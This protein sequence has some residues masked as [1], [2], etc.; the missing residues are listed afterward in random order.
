M[1]SGK[2]LRALA[3]KRL[4]GEVSEEQFRLELSAEKDIKLLRHIA[5]ELT[6]HSEV[7]IPAYQ[8]A[9]ELDPGDPETVVDLGFVHWLCGE[10]DQARNCLS[11]AYRLAP[12]HVKALLL[13][14]AL[15]SDPLKKRE[16]YKKVLEKDPENQIAIANLR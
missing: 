8:R 2:V 7:S 11:Q 10:D 1:N 3:K 5:A 16:L 14:A 12:G 6:P 9:M 15:E 4:T 13:D